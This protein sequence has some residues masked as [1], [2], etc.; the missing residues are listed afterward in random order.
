MFPGIYSD[1]NLLVPS[2]YV[3]KSA[4]LMA[5][6]QSPTFDELICNYDYRFVFKDISITYLHFLTNNLAC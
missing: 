2:P 5:D 1:R 6:I 4:E 3:K